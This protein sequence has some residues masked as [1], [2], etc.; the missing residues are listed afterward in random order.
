MLFSTHSLISLWSQYVKQSVQM[1][2]LYYLLKR[3]IIFKMK[4]EISG[5]VSL[6]SHK[7]LSQL[8]QPQ[9]IGEQN[10]LVDG[11]Y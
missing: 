4:K 3:L 9:Q 1:Y 2:I 5:F 10:I 8:F 7:T 6:K 11:S